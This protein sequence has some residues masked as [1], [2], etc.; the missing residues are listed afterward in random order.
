MS[1]FFN[2]VSADLS[3]LTT[4]SAI[5]KARPDVVAAAHC[6]SLYG[7]TWS[8]FGRPIDTLQQDGCL[9]H[10]NLSVYESYGGI[11]LAPEEGEN[12]A[13][14][15]GPKHKACILKNHGLLTRTWHFLL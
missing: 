15:L 1:A 8:A 9:F 6:H 4:D 7:K 11:V 14:A 3:H 5:H 12:I 10:D 2:I 13:A